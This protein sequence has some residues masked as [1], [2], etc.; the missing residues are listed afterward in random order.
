MY[1]FGKKVDKSLNGMLII[2]GENPKPIN[3]N[4]NE[5]EICEPVIFKEDLLNID[6]YTSRYNYHISVGHC[7]RESINKLLDKKLDEA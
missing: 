4:Y 3:I 1:V 7:V 6:K 2:D 5:I